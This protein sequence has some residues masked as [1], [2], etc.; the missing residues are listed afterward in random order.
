MCFSDYPY[1]MTVSDT[2]KYKQEIKA[3]KE[4]YKG[5]I[6]ILLAYE[7]EYF[8]ELESYYEEL[9]NNEADYLIF[10]NLIMYYKEKIQTSR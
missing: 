7:C 6:D 5:K 9:L 1:Q 4:K 3:L 10:G 8:E 2:E